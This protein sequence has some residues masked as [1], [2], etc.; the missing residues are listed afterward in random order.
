M[1]IF[2]QQSMCDASSPSPEPPGGVAMSDLARMIR[3]QRIEQRLTQA[4]A[5]DRA[6]VSLATW[7]SL[8][9]ETMD[10]TG[11]QD[12]TL[13]GA[14]Q[15]LRVPLPTVY[16]WAGRPLPEIRTGPGVPPP[17]LSVEEQIDQLSAM[18]RRLAGLSEMSY[19]LAYG[20]AVEVADHLIQLHGT[21][22][23]LQP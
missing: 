21:D 1:G 12:L 4:Q 11:F 16:G 6:G 3:R 22:R 14:A 15:G 2:K 19:L 20:Q 8:E 17:D 10:P 9:R 5:A 7:Q 13:A 18:L 23:E